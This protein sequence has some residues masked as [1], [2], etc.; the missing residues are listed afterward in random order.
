MFVYGKVLLLD[1][2]RNPALAAAFR[3]SNR[4]AAAERAR[5]LAARVAAWLDDPPHEVANALN[6]LERDAAALHREQQA[7][8]ALADLYDAMTGRVGTA[9]VGR[10]IRALAAS[11]AADGARTTE[12]DHASFQQGRRAS[13]GLTWHDEFARCPECG[14]ATVGLTPPY[15]INH[16]AGCA[17]ALTLSSAADGAER[18]PCD[19]CKTM[20]RE[21]TPDCEETKAHLAADGAET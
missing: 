11:S 18:E 7:I 6:A 1:A 13:S 20:G 12:D 9:Q 14:N 10:N 21:W 2:N 5:V 19:Y 3:R 8:H 4:E 16:A 17:A 15:G